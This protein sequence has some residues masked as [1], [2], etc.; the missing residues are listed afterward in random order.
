LQNGVMDKLKKVPFLVRL[1]KL[2]APYGD[3]VLVITNSEDSLSADDVQDEDAV[4]WQVEQ[5]HRELKQLTGIEKCQCR[6]Q[7]PQRNHIACC[8]QAWLAIKIKADE[9]GKTL[10]ALVDDLLYEYLRAERRDPR[11]PALDTA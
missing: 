11:I 3:I 9:V 6:K 7:R 2:V 4:R 8:Y 1:F 10:Y 5:L